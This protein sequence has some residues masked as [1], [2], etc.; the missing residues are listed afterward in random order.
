MISPGSRRSSSDVDSEKVNTEPSSE[1]E[2][3][4]S[5]VSADRTLVVSGITGSTKMA[6]DITKGKFRE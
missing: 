5:V 4:L 3:R 2:L 6:A 1:M